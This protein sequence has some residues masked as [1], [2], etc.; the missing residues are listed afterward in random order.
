MQRLRVHQHYIVTEDGQPFFWL[1]DTA[2]ELFHR[3]TLDEAAHYFDNRRDK[4]IN[5][6]QA[7]VLAELDGLQTPN[8]IGEIPFHDLD[9]ARPNDAYFDFVEQ[10]IQM[11]AERGL[12]MAV[13]PTW[14]DKVNLM[15]GKGPQIFTTDNAGAYGRYL[16]KR[17]SGYDNVVWMIGG[18]RRAVEN[19]V[20]YRPVWRAMAEGVRA[21]ADQLTTYHPVGTR[22]SS[23]EFHH[24]NWLD[25]NSWQ[26]GHGALD[27]PIW[28]RIFWDWMQQPVKPVFDSEPCY[29]DIPVQFDSANGYFTPYDIRRR[30]YRGVFAGG[31]GVTYGHASIWQMYSA[32]HAPE[33]HAHIPWDESLD[34]PAAF[35]IVHL[36]NLMLSRPYLTRIPDQ[37]LLL[38]D[39]GSGTHHV[40]ATRDTD[41]TYAFIYIPTSRQTVKL[42]LRRLQGERFS[43]SWFDPRT[44]V[45]SAIGEVARQ[46]DPEFTTPWPGPDQVLVIDVI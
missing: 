27:E 36:K 9:P 40:R 33:L 38:S 45:T 34:R 43:V 35:Q 46:D 12:Y 1:G 2:W 18:D 6:I 37:A 13:L 23:L 21:E 29:E 3:R 7:V 44:G 17:L 30:V 15:W 5:V 4:G 24:D 16:G 11:A 8:R 22:G 31:C 26:S 32:E 41:G 25:V 14:G 10:M 39:E 19:G 42:N 20:D 28:D